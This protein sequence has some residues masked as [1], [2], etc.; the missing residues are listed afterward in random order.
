M[1]PTV[2]KLVVSAGVLFSV[3]LAHDVDFGYGALF[4][5]SLEETLAPVELSGSV[6]DWLTGTFLRNGPG[7]FDGPNGP[8]RNFTFAWDGYSKVQKYTFKD[9]KVSY[10]TRFPGNQRHSTDASVRDYR[11]A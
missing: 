5:N 8:K 10:Q 4:E 9:G 6:P 3:A 7:R 2:L 11:A 1:F